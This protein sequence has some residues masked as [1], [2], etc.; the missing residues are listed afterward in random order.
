MVSG[1]WGCVR[2]A[3]ACT[4]MH[5]HAHI[6]DTHTR[7]HTHTHIHTHTHRPKLVVVDWMAPY[8]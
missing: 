6:S 3:L 4:R 2:G 1:M 7:T 5:T 8:L